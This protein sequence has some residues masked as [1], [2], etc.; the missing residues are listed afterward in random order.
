[1][2]K[3]KV[4]L[5]L[6]LSFI[7][8]ISLVSFSYP[9]V[10]DVSNFLGLLAISLIALV[11][12]YKNKKV[13]LAGFTILFFIFGAFAANLKI[14]K[15]NQLNK[16]RINF[17]AVVRVDNDPKISGSYQRIIVK[18]V[19]NDVPFNH[20]ISRKEKILVN[21]GVYPSYSYGDELRLSCVLELPKNNFGRG[22]SIHAEDQELAR[23]EA[24]SFDYRMYLA[25]DGIYYICN[26]PQI[27]KIGQSGGNMVFGVILKVK[28]RFQQNIEKLI[29]A[30]ESGL[31]SG[32][33]IGGGGNLSQEI[34]DNFSRTGMTHIVAVS[35]YNVAIVAEYLMLFGI[36]IGLWRKQAFWLAVFGI[37]IFII[38]VGLPSSAVRAGVMGILL[39]WAI[40]NGRLANSQNAL[41]FAAALMLA[42]NPL[43]LRWD[44]GF[45]LSF[46]AT[47]GIIYIYPVFQNYFSKLEHKGL[48][49]FR[50][51]LLLTLSAQVFVLPVILFNFHNLSLISPLANLLVLPII[52]I[53]MLLG[54]L[55]AVSEFI[56]PPLAMAFSWLAYLP[57]KYETL[58]INFLA[59]LRYSSLEMINFSWIWVIIWYV[60]LLLVI[61]WL[62]KNVQTQKKI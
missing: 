28:N 6:S 43:L 44:I 46:L 36:F 59:H 17:L 24:S 50:E 4:F 37:I 2:K 31:L 39:I 5:W 57:L 34:Q 45:Q 20:S 3:S 30:P 9:R 29:P 41:I 49:A 10:V 21:A 19:A 7:G 14:T 15:I 22:P 56:F 61:Y 33:I 54:F 16:N 26:R 1:M 40:K 27:E 23:D 48:N 18:K 12:F 13:L 25:K 32:L 53:T 55:A 60:T 62:Q 11:V 47:L 51:I 38:L 58:V 8:G 42:A 52:P 35:G